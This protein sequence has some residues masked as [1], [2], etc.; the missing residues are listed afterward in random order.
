M[1]NTDIITI[2]MSFSADSNTCVWISIGLSL[3]YGLFFP[4]SLHSWKVFMLSNFVNF[5][6]LSIGYFWILQI[7]LIFI[8]WFSYIT[9]RCF[10]PSGFAFNLAHTE[11][12]PFS[13]GR[14]C[15]TVKAKP[16]WVFYMI[17]LYKLGFSTLA[18]INQHLQYCNNLEN[19]CL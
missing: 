8:L 6:L 7:L 9:Q 4:A 14:I 18:N 15:P 1:W 5:T 12:A 13:L 10:D 17:F 19:C 16:F 11:R 2:L 3:Q